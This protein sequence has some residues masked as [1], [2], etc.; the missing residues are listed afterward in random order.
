MYRCPYLGLDDDPGMYC[1]FANLHHRCYK[2]GER[3]KIRLDHQASF[4]LQESYAT[5]LGHRRPSPAPVKPTWRPLAITSAAVLLFALSALFVWTR[6]SQGS[7]ASA[8]EPAAPSAVVDDELAEAFDTP[9]AVLPVFIPAERTPQTYQTEL[10]TVTAT[11]TASSP[12]ATATISTTLES[13]RRPETTRTATITST[14][15]ST[16]V[17][18]TPSRTPSVTPSPTSSV[19]VSPT[20]TPQPRQQP[21][22]S[23]TPTSQTQRVHVVVAGETL[24]GIAND[25]HTTVDEL[26]Q[27]NGLDNPRYVYVGQR[28]IIP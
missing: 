14:V 3:E 9:A 18:A 2:G 11:S 25:Y 10:P 20:A 16:Q 4:C 27:A 15:V 12:T 13:Q 22:S 17:S 8:T 19:T 23:T 5:C 26:A 6:G 7:R 21:R 1:L 28:L 24:S